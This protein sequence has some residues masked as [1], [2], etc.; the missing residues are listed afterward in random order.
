MRGGFGAAL[1]LTIFLA[2]AWSQG[3]KVPDVKEIMSKLNK[4]TG[5]Y[6]A[7]GKELKANDTDW[8]EVNDQAKT[9]LRYANYLTKTAPPRGDNASWVRLTKTY[10]DNAKALRLAAAKEDKKAT[11]AAYERMGGKTCD[12]CHELHRPK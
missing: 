1:T 4:P 9:I 10:V 7:L 5:I 2:P 11:L 12:A 8:D 3:N 6:F